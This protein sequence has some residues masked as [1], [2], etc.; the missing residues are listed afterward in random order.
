MG[1]LRVNLTNG[2]STFINLGPEYNEVL[3][4][5]A[6][7]QLTVIRAN[8]QNT[9]VW[10]INRY[11]TTPKCIWEGQM[12]VAYTAIAAIPVEYGYPNLGTN[13]NEYIKYDAS[14]FG[15]S[16]LQQ[17]L[18]GQVEDEIPYTERTAIAENVTSVEE[19]EKMVAE[20]EAARKDIET[21]AEELASECQDE[22]SNGNTFTW[23]NG[24]ICSTEACCQVTKDEY[25]A[26]QLIPLIKNVVGP[27]SWKHQYLWEAVQSGGPS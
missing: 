26:E 9:D 14:K 1:A 20:L 8:G 27:I 17:A 3:I 10:S 6:T 25:I 13:K 11:Q 19:A 21:E 16:A 18:S 5:E 24:V 22:V 12:N 15:I 4:E 23:P 7:T 2:T